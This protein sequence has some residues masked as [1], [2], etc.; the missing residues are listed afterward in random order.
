[1]KNRTIICIILIILFEVLSYLFK[2][3]LGNSIYLFNTIFF[4][5]TALLCYIDIG[6]LNY[7]KRTKIDSIQLIIIVS[8]LFIF[9]NFIFGI[10]RG[11]SNS[12]INILLIIYQLITL[13]SIEII[14]YSLVKNVSKRLRYLVSFLF[15]LPIIMIF[16]LNYNMVFPI[17]ISSIMLTYITSNVGLIPCI[18]YGIL[19][20]IYNIIPIKPNIDFV[21]NLII[22]LVINILLFI[23]LND[24]YK[25]DLANLNFVNKKQSKIIYILLV[26][27]ISYVLLVLG[28]SNYKLIGIMS[29]SMKPVFSRG[30]GVIMKKIDGNYYDNLKVGDIL[31]YE[32]D[33]IYVVHRV[34]KKDNGLVITKGDNNI[35]NDDPVSKEQYRGIVKIYI[36]LIGY[37]NVWLSK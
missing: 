13:V 37:P 32:K 22:I 27:I 14:R 7:K 20:N 17:L 36:P 25:K 23:L 16:N 10:F 28:V 35:D 30:T 2:N 29:D 24:L 12:N 33:N 18:I 15:V 1:M 26:I 31:V 11:F 6:S 3:I 19:I 4:F 21:V 5:I 9:I 8:I 34:I